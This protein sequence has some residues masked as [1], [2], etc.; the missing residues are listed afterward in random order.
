MK[1][2]QKRTPLM[3][4]FVQFLID[5]QLFPFFDLSLRFAVIHT[6]A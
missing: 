4:S 2:A 1:I 5:L 6:K 3:A